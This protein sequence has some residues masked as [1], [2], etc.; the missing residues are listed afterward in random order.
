[1]NEIDEYIDNVAAPKIRQ[2]F[3]KAFT[4]AYEDFDAELFSLYF[5]T[6]CMEGKDHIVRLLKQNYEQKKEVLSNV[7]K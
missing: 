4:E 5:K 2:R 7:S 3:A 6:E 1:M